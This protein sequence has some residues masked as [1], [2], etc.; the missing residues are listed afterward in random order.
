MFIY[1]TYTLTCHQARTKGFLYKRKISPATD[2]PNM[3]TPVM[4][5][6]I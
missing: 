3:Q 5:S 6:I 4:K 2:K 1:Q